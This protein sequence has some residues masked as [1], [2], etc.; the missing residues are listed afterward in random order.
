MDSHSRVFIALRFLAMQAL[1]NL[2]LMHRS[3]GRYRMSEEP[4]QILQSPCSD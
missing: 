1:N 4:V 2:A 3:M